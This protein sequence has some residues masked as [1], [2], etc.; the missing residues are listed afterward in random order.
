MTV[1][2]ISIYFLSVFFITSVSYT[3]ITAKQII[4]EKEV[5]NLLQIDYEQVFQERIAHVSAED[6]LVSVQPFVQVEKCTSIDGMAEDRFGNAVSIDGDT[7][8]VGAANADVGGNNNQ[9]A[10]YIFIRSMGSWIQQAKLTSDDGA[11]DDYFGGFV[12]ID[13]DTA[14][15]GAHWAEVDGVSHRGAVYIFTRD[16][17]IWT[18]KTKLTASDAYWLGHSVEING[19]AIIAGARRAE[20]NGINQQGAAYVFRRS[21]DEWVL[22]ARLAANDGMSLD[23][24]GSSVALEGNIALV[25]SPGSDISEV[26]DQGA[27]YVFE[28]FG[29]NWIQQAKLVTNDGNTGNVFGHSVALSESIAVVGA[30][31]T[32]IGGITNQGAAYIFT[33]VGATWTF[34]TALT[35]TDSEKDRS[36]GHQVFADGETVL[37]TSGRVDEE[38]NSTHNLIYVFTKL[39]GNWTQQDKLIASDEN[40]GNGFGYSIAMNG[41]K[42]IAGA[43]GA[44]VGDNTNQGAVYFFE[45]PLNETT[46][47]PMILR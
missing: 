36:F 15:V 14:I 24:F 22:E 37:V 35:S 40:E 41:N 2:K 3:T 26:N 42:L 17:E 46:Y 38:G 32:D 25:G 45:K 18:Q 9:G 23:E 27:V 5:E 6:L 39:D 28:R 16:G 20:V 13:G 12:S 7:A 10:A 11:T 44:D 8:I 19:D 43:I 34:V 4:R 33:K 31:G 21:G 30:P 1:L 47:L 29:G